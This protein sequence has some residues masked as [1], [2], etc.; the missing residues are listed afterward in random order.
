MS[1]QAITS[2]NKTRAEW[3]EYLDDETIAERARLVREANRANGRSGRVS[4]RM[5][6][7]SSK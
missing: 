7:W 1:K 6:E 4:T 5:G 2:A 3:D